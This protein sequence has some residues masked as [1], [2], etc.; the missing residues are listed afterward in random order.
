MRDS[1]DTTGFMSCG[2]RMLAL[3]KKNGTDNSTT[4]MIVSRR[5]LKEPT[6]RPSA[7]RDF[8]Q[9]LN[10]IERLAAAENDTA[11]RIITDHDGQACFFAQQ[12]VDV[13]EQRTAAGE[14]HTLVDDVAGHLG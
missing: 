2:L 14:H 4:T 8:L 6:A 10:V 5:R 7:D 13:L 1:A 3:K 12:N 11:D 9:E